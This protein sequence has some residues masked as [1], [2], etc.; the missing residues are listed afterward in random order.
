MKKKI[1]LYLI[2]LLLVFPFCYADDDSWIY[3]SEKMTIDLTISSTIKI[4][5]ESPNYYVDYIKAKISFFPQDDF[6]QKL[7]RFETNPD[8]MK[9]EN[10]ME[11]YW[12]DGNYKTLKFS[13]D[14]SIQTENK[15]MEIKKKIDFPIKSLDEEYSLYTE[16][17]ENFDINDEIVMLASEIVQGEDDLYIAVHKIAEWV[18]ENVE[19]DLKYGDTTEKSSWVLKNKVGTCDEISALF[20]SLCRAVKIPARY[21]SGIAYSNI[22]ELEGF[23]NHAWADVYF[24]GYGWVP[25]DVTYKEFGMIN[26]THVKMKTSFDSRELSTSYEWKGRNFEIEAEKLDV[27]AKVIDYFGEKSAM[28]SIKT[29][30]FEDNIGF[31]SYNIIEASVENLKDYYVP[32][33]IFL[34]A[35]SEI[36]VEQE[37]SKSFVL[38]PYETKKMYWI[39]ELTDDLRR[40]YVYTI[41]ISVYDSMN[42]SSTST[43]ISK[44][45]ELI[46]SKK[47]IEDALEGM[48]EEDEKVY[49]RNLEISCNLDKEEYYTNDERKIDCYVKNT[50]NVILEKVNVCCDENCKTINIGIAQEKTVIFS[51]NVYG[52]GRQQAKISAK[53][54][55]VSRT[56]YL[57]YEVMDPPKIEIINISYPKE[58]KYKQDYEISFFVNKTSYSTPKDVNVMITQN[59]FSNEWPVHELK[60]SQKININL[61]S[62]ILRQGENK[63]NIIVRF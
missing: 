41:P 6:Q 5:P 61:N 55:D 3:K 54:S 26:P 25:F 20:I 30:F 40:N 1:I 62:R 56:E 19:Y 17:S 36:Y 38:N 21:V 34:S 63:F 47:E 23:G 12:E 32:A 7:L 10:F 37:K 42:S 48:I 24:P 43:F 27:N 39:L 8:S 9:K 51:D 22:P 14:Y 13:L 4:V 58:V 33:R 31:G 15:I 59:S 11:F 44:S 16:P 28:V 57:S 18:S 53:S 45:N 35:P 49:S 46:I 50:G 29:K 2:L 60:E 52:I